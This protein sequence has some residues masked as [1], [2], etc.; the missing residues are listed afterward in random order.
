[1]FINTLSKTSTS[2]NPDVLLFSIFVS[3]LRPELITFLFQNVTVTF[4]PEKQLE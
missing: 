3:T 4:F 2:G 1:V